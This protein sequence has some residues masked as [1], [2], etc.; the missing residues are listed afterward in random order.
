MSAAIVNATWKNHPSFDV[1][2]GAFVLS[3]YMRRFREF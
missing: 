1:Y 2:A 3:A